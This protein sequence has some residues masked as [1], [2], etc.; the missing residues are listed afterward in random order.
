M[1]N[2]IALTKDMKLECTSVWLSP[3][4]FTGIVSNTVDT[5]SMGPK[6]VHAVLEGIVSN[7]VD[8]DSMGP[9]HAQYWR[10]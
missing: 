9:K 5:D 10:V 7:T 4:P 1:G 8:T 3:M 6:H 2:D